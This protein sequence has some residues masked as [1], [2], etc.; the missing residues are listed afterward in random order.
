MTTPTTIFDESEWFPARLA[1]DY[2]TLY[3]I[4]TNID[5]LKAAPF[6]DQRFLNTEFQFTQR[7]ICEVPLVSAPSEPRWIFHS[8]YCCSTLLTAAM[9]ATASCHVLRE[10]DILMGLANAKR[11]L[12]QSEKGK[13]R[14]QMLFDRIIPLLSRTPDHRPIILKPTNAANN[15]LEEVLELGH[16]AVIIMSSLADFLVSVIKKGEACRGFV[17][18]LYNVFSMDAF[19]LDHF[20]ARQ[21][22]AFTDLQM[23]TL[24]WRAQMELFSNLIERYPDQVVTL[25]DREFLEHKGATLNKLCHHFH[26]DA[27]ESSIGA[28]VASDVFETN[29]KI[30]DQRF[31]A[32]A[33]EEEAANIQAIFGEDI[34]I[35]NKWAS[36]VRL[37]RDIEFPL[38]NR[39]LLTPGALAPDYRV[40]L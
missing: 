16:R 4:K 22:I 1:N 15:L 24:V 14:Y 5:D 27:D 13:A 25:T 33:R 30:A 10:P 36:Q 3:F 23:A 35:M 40:S 29:A 34:A 18:T 6:L 21:A 28:V 7:S 11:M 31:N 9:N 20:P 2:E 17:R 8:S 26:V 32:D 19:G 38:P 37:K 12:S 39:L